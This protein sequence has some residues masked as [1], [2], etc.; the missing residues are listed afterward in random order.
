MNVNLN[1]SKMNNAKMNLFKLFIIVFCSTL[2][3]SCDE[4]YNIEN[5]TYNSTEFRILKATVS[6]EAI[7]SGE[8][9]PAFGLSIELIFN[10]PVD[11]GA[12]SSGLSISNNASYSGT[13]DSTGS[14]LTIA[15]DPLEYESSYEISLPKGVYGQGGEQ[16]SEDFILAFNT[17]EFVAP[18]VLLSVESN[19]ISEGESSVISASIRQPSS[20]D[21][22]IYFTFSGTAAVGE[23][24]QLGSQSISIPIGELSGTT[25]IDITDDELVEGAEFLEISILSVLN[26][27]DN[28]QKLRIDIKDNDVALELTLKGVMALEWASSG[29]NGG[30]ALHFKAVE[31]I[32]DLSNYAIGVA[33]N[34]DGSDSIEYRFPTMAVSAGDDI[35]LAREDAT[36]SS[37]LGDGIN[38]FEHVIQS[39]EMNQNGNDAIELYSGT[40]II[41]TYGDADVDGEGQEWEYTGGWAYKLGDGWVYSGLNCGAGSSSTVNSNCVYPLSSSPI[42]FKGAMEIETDAGIRIRAYHFEALQDVADAGIYKVDI[43][44][45][46]NTTIF[47]TVQLPNQPADEGENILVVRDLDVDDVPVYFTSCAEK[48]TVYENTEVTSNGDDALVFLENDVPLD[49]LGEVGVDGTGLSWEYANS[50][51]YRAVPGA[52]FMFGGADCTNSATTNDDADCFYPFCN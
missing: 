32:A 42:Y 36:L 23:D 34:G 45:N 44:N 31:D 8:S 40:T 29:T 38:A 1:I 14:I 2:L 28:D 9:L 5:E 11:Q 12:I 18:E 21:V 4:D 47:R 52:P 7:N 13:Y 37:Y 27:V 3:M 48:F 6:D 49:T 35:L 41:E 43:Y 25:T 26:G 16:L 10:S 50:Y 39:D 51:G 15:F 20:E 30:K 33:N 17:S 46:G 19:A 24:Y 22:T